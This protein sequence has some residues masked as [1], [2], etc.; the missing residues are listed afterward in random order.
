MMAPTPAVPRPY[1]EEH[2]AV[3]PTW[4]VIAVGCAGIGIVRVIAPCADRRT[5]DHGSSDKRGT[6]SYIFL[7]ILSHC[8]HRER[9]S[10]QHCNQN[11]PKSP[12]NILLVLTCA[13]RPA[14]IGSGNRRQH[15]SSALPASGFIFPTGFCTLRQHSRG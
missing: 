7:D 5:V 8:R 6:D 9:H 2:A 3:E 12:H 1:A 11:Q 15:P 14:S 10:Q 13:A 4:P